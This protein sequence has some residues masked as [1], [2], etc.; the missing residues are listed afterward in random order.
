MALASCGVE[1]EQILFFWPFAG[2][3]KLTSA[4]RNI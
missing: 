4:A 2:E 3:N 1:V